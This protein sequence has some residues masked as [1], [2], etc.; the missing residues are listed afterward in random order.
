MRCF[1]AGKWMLLCSL[2]ALWV[3]PVSEAKSSLDFPDNI[4]LT[5]TDGRTVDSATLKSAPLVLMV[6][7]SWCPDCKRQAPE[8][9]KAYKNYKDKGVI[10]L[11]VLAKSTRADIKDFIVTYKVT[12]PVAGDNTIADALRVGPVPQTFFY[13]PG[14]FFSKRIYGPVTYGELE[15]NIE[16]ILGPEG[17]AR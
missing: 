7:A 14:G 13:Y 16:R 8:V 3:V 17:K 10:F 15:S 2:V 4:T 5:T 11:C 12:Y 6:S 1:K 9:Q